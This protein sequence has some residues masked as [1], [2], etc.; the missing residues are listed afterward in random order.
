M[1]SINEKRE[2]DEYYYNTNSSNQNKEEK[3]MNAQKEYLQLKNQIDILKKERDYIERKIS[4]NPYPLG[5][6]PDYEKLRK[7]AKLK[8]QNKFN[9]PNNINNNSN[10][11]KIT[12]GS[13]N[14]A[15][16]THKKKILSQ[17]A[18]NEIYSDVGSTRDILEGFVDRCVDRSLYVYR[19]KNCHT[20][21]KLLAMGKSTSNCPKC[22]N[23]FKYPINSRTTRK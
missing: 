18:E 10:R 7:K 23:E 5:Y 13:D 15:N 3:I 16:K 22:H 14:F 20:C 19:N 8:M 11:K 9:S 17:L 1:N 12:F 4:Q 6:I 2:T 21:T